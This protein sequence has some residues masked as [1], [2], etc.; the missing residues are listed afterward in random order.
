MNRYPLLNFHVALIE[1]QIPNNTG[2]IGRLCVATHSRLHLVHPLGF[3]VTDSRVKRSGL[4]YWPELE[5]MEH[6]DR[7]SFDEEFLQGDNFYLF[8]AHGERSLYD[9]TLKRED[10]LVFGREADG[11][12]KEMLAS[13]ASR[14]VR[15]PFPGKVRSFNLAN[16]VSMVL[17]EK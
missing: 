7:Q 12:P 11:L 9:I 2:N 3:E 4:D 13:Y 8:S 1:P 14:T 10:V 5:W 6:A 16:A 17:G 15:I